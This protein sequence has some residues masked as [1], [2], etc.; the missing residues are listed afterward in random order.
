MSYEGKKKLN[1]RIWNVLHVVAFK[2]S[3]CVVY[4]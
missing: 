2:E 3:E 1:F 4:L